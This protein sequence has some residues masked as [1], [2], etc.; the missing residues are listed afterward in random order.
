M[1]LKYFKFIK[2]EK[3][4]VSGVTNLV[5][6]IIADADE[7][8]PSFQTEQAA[9]A[10]L[11]STVDVILEPNK[12]VMV[13]VGFSAEIPRGYHAKIVA[14]SSMGKKGI[15]VPNAPGIIDSDYRNRI[16]VLL[17][18]LSGQNFEIKKGDR[19][20]QWILEQNTQYCWCKVDQLGETERG[21]GGFGST[22]R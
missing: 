1:D 19:V 21:F 22:G 20:A 11:R 2:E 14:R 13:D 6:K 4:N 16:C 17:L 3:V 7:F 12:V 18:N 10:D 15:I 5:V 9:G 8:I